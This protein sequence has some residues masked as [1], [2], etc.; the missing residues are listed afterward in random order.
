MLNQSQSENHF[1]HSNQS[2]APKDTILNCCIHELF[3]R[4]VEKTPDAVAV[5]FGEQSLSYAELNRR[6]N[7]LARFLREDLHVGPDTLV[8]VCVERSIEMVVAL[9]AVL[10]AGGA[11][12]PLDPHYPAERLDYMLHDAAPRALLSHGAVPVVVR[13]LLDQYA[14]STNV[15]VIDLEADVSQWSGQNSDDLHPAD[16]G[17]T[18]S[19]LAYV[20]YTSGSTGRPKGVMNQHVGVVNR[21]VW[22]Q[23]AYRLNA[24]DA[25]LQKTP[26]SFDVS[27]WEF[28]WPLMYGAR[29]VVAKPEGHKDPAYL[30]ALI[31]EHRITTLHFVPSMLSAFLDQAPPE[32]GDCLQRVFCSGEALPA[33]SVHRFRE[34]FAKVEL[35]N[36]YGPTEAAID[37][38]AW[39]CC[40]DETDGLIPEN[41][42]PIGK[43]IDNI[44]LYILDADGQPCPVGVA[45]ELHIAGVG[46][47]RGYLNQPELTA[48][49]FIKNP[50]SPAL[51]GVMY[52]TGDL[53]RYL[54]GGDIEYL[55]R[56]DFQVKL[57]G[58]RIEL[59]EIEARLMKHPV[60]RDAVV[61]A[62]GES[63]EDKRLVGFVIAAERALQ[64]QSR[65]SV[66]E[67]IQRLIND[68]VPDYM[69]LAA[70]VIVSGFPLSASGKI[71]RKSFPVVTF[72]EFT[73]QDVEPPKNALEQTLVEVWSELLGVK[74]IGRNAH[75]FNL[76]GHSLLT[77]KMV[78]ALRR[79]GLFVDGYTLYQYPVLSELATQLQ[80]SD[81]QETRSDMAER[82][83]VEASA[84][85]QLSQTE[86]NVLTAA[87]P[88][89][90]ANIQDIYP[91]GALQQGMIYH[92]LTNLAGDPYVLWQVVRFRN[93]DL[94]HAYVDALRGT[95][96]RH[97]A[98]RVSVHYEG[99]SQ[100][101]QV[102][103]RDAELTVEE[104]KPTMD[105]D[106]PL[107]ILKQHC[108]PAML[109]FDITKAPLQRCIYC[110]DP[111]RDEWVLLHLIHHMTVDHTTVEKMQQEIE[112]QLRSE[113]PAPIAPISFRQVNAD[114]FCATGAEAQKAFF[115]A[116]L[117]DYEPTPAPF[118]AGEYLGGNAVV[119]EAWRPLQERLCSQIRQQAKAHGVSAAA[120]FHLAWAKVIACLTGC[121][122][123]VF[124]TVLLGRMFAGENAENIMGPFINTLPI[125]VRLDNLAVFECLWN[126]QD[127]LTQ[128]VRH[129]QASLALAQK[130]VQTPGTAPLFTS[131]LNYR[132]SEVRNIPSSDPFQAMNPSSI[133]GVSYSGSME[134]THYPVSV[135]IDDFTN[136]FVINAQV[137]QGLDPELIC[138]YLQTALQE[139]VTA[140]ES[141]PERGIGRIHVLPA[142]EKDKLLWQWNQTT[143]DFPRQ[144]CLHTLI[145]EQARRTPD[146][147]AVVFGDQVLSYVQL[148]Q[149][150]NQLARFLREDLHVGPD[151]LVGVC[152]ERSIEMVVALLAVLKAGGAYVPLDPHYPAERLDYMLHDAAPRALLSH[153][154]VS[155]G[156]RALLDQYAMSTNVSVIDLEADVSQWFGQNSDDLYPADNGLTS[157]HLAY[158][159]YTSGSTGRPKGVMNQHVGVVNR[160]VW[161][162]KAYRLNANDAVLQKTPFSFDVSVWEFFWP[163]MYGAR[164]VVAK[165]EG[166][167]DP[168]YLSALIQEHRITTLHFVPSMLSAFLDQALPEVGDC[169]QRVF[170]S[171]EA[172][173]ARSVHRFRERF[174]KVELHNLYGPTE[175]AIDVTAWNCCLDETDGLIPK[176][177]I[178]IGKPIDNIQLYILDVYGQPCPVGVAGELH[179]AG[180]GVARG[181]LNQPKLTAEKFIRDPFSPVLNGVMYRTGDLAR[182]LP[183]G[184]IEYLGRNDFQVKLRGFRIELGEVEAALLSHDSVKE[185]VVLVRE[186]VPGDA[187]LVAYATPA[188][189][190]VDQ[191]PEER[192]QTLRMHLQT[193]LPL[194]MVPSHLLWLDAFPLTANGKLD[195]KALPSPADA[196]MG[197]TITVQPPQEG[198]ET[199][200]AQL[201]AELLNLN[202]NAI[203]RQSHFFEAGGHSLLAVA[204]MARIQQAFSVSLLLSAIVEH[205]DLASQAELIE[206]E[207]EKGNAARENGDRAHLTEPIEPTPVEQIRALPTQKAIYKAV[208]LNPQDL[209]NNSFLAL[210]FDDDVEPD[211]KQLRNLL[212]SVLSR[213]ESLRA[214]FI[215]TGDELY[216]RPAKRF[217][218]RLE[219][220]QTLGALEEDLRDFIRP[221]SLEDGMN[222]RGR[223]VVDG[224]RPL[225]LLDVSHACVDGSGLMQI[226]SEL[227]A[228]NDPAPS[229]TRL[230]TYSELFYSREFATLRQEHADFWRTQLQ[231]WSPLVHAQ[232]TESVTHTCLIT[233]DAGLKGQIET[234][235][236]R[237][238][239]SVPEFFMAA[240]LLFK[241]RLD[242]QP[243]QFNPHDQLT[244]MIFHGRDRLDQQTVIAPL[245][246]VLPVRVR[247]RGETMEPEMLHEV[248]VAVRTA[249]R[250]YLFD[251]EELTVRYPALAKQ[252][253]SPTSFFG[254]FQKEGFDGRIAGRLCRQLETP[255]VAGGQS[256]W[257]LTCEIA[258]HTTG[259]DVHLEALSFRTG[260]DV[261]NWEALFKSIVQS[262]LSVE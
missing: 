163:L 186:D 70:I 224:R 82:S 191:V 10:K 117:R 214:Q 190:Y 233:L 226:L 172:L 64:R 35:H 32:V 171:G 101:V 222:V 67:S 147:I 223:W 181:Y 183:G 246:S 6:A 106:D 12:V 212:Q 184:D 83:M 238:K 77:L 249:C 121:N 80:V 63:A 76:G 156:V 211:L 159:I 21:L 260:S 189:G 113:P 161:M 104:L 114:L 111:K 123:V 216:L 173:P 167:K 58:F 53:A 37:V 84:W 118:G 11:Y 44:Q 25:V 196:P 243:A 107:V 149:K 150:A 174:A 13:A 188:S 20:I 31:Q 131:L 5:R 165:P 9:L 61:L 55:G 175:A 180:V 72:D 34:R 199:R 155:A 248:S 253:L 4:Q 28:F 73:A 229:G 3:E 137:E 192:N 219:K 179:I 256:H 250:H 33:R 46:V 146:A 115:D 206:T 45:G 195:R 247:L 29:L 170:C 176:N 141:A 218:F 136:D 48:E 66:K 78:L 168:A 50:F 94:L 148:N 90:L 258:E 239:I 40:L 178:P 210:S 193:N 14:M 71:D 43:P 60:V 57:R 135:N 81:P 36:L 1:D 125:R 120:V 19:H 197:Q 47:A 162:Q 213:H 182:Y 225:L 242:Y 49:K 105:C 237:L 164:L 235:T 142:Q 252:A 96:A 109:R 85:A 152:V 145:E 200:L 30:S 62:Q 130:S 259:F 38:T 86:I 138:D 65:E 124:G 2:R 244:S 231:E 153:G 139:I 220:R 26:F 95:I 227:A 126:A 262:A 23:K 122:D 100:P 103:W 74:N 128:L 22:M 240:F 187:R 151:T 245:M 98:F 79:R 261:G 202:T 257:N 251:A 93:A 157:S 102:V 203:G 68:A 143:S 39:N 99:L 208:K 205:L 87:I 215:L 97:D 89:G 127:T 234:L 198:T 8:G 59:G 15:S 241:A 75:F 110:Y 221:F 228:E 255:N 133:N 201:W 154:A 69:R 166:H 52:R 236:S 194:F 116:M 129:E 158:V 51:N 232:D 204:L 254:Y 108:D 56:N 230:A 88:G 144:A 41:V 140:L 217:L 54:P 132:H 27:V 42:I 91:L 177:V 17:L 119:V 18:S 16:N 185:C 92:Y 7:Q 207:I 24:N 209:S 169:L 134:R 160:L 112:A